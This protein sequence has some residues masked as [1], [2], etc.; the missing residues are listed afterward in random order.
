MDASKTTEFY[1]PLVY[2]RRG[3]EPKAARAQA[4][5]ATV[6]SRPH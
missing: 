1:V 2:G 4:L 6:R 3:A 5:S